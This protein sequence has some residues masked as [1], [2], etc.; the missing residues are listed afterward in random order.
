MR[1]KKTGI[2]GMSE[3]AK[4][5]KE[6]GDAPEGKKKKGKLPVIIVLALL[7]GGGGFFGMKMRGGGPK[8]VPPIK[9]GEIVEIKEEFLSNMAEKNAYVRAKISLQVK[10][11]F[12]KEEIES[13]LAAIQDVINM[14]LHATS[15]RS[16]ASLDGLRNLKKDLATDLNKLL[17]ESEKKDGAED[18]T[19]PEDKPKDEKSKD[20]KAKPEDKPEIPEGWDSAKGPVL[21]VLFVSFA[22][23]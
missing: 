23:Q 21:K 9:L 2:A 15:V 4:E 22:T 10:D 20:G 12:K 5:A 19:K 8:K 18:K 7:L 17:E 14:K 13:K 3:Q 16:V 6:A 1:N 11:G